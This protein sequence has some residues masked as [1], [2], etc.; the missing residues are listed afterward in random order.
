MQEVGLEAQHARTIYTVRTSET[1]TAEMNG[2]SCSTEI[3]SWTE[4]ASQTIT[5]ANFVPVVLY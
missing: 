2:E 1:R 4:A 5:A 3:T